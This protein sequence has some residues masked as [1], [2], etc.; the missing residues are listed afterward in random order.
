MGPGLGQASGATR[1]SPRPVILPEHQPGS[2]NC[3][4]SEA[5]VL[6]D[7]PGSSWGV[8][9]HECPWK[10]NSGDFTLIHFASSPHEEVD[11]RGPLG[12]PWAAPQHGKEALLALSHGWTGTPR[13][14]E[15]G[16][17]R[18]GVRL[19][20]KLG[21]A[22]LAAHSQTRASWARPPV[23]ETLA[24]G[25]AEREPLVRPRGHLWA[26]HTAPSLCVR[27]SFASSPSRLTG[28][29]QPAPWTSPEAR[30]GRRA[31]RPPADSCRGLGGPESTRAGA[32]PQPLRLHLGP[33]CT[34]V[35]RGPDSPS[36][37]C[38]PPAGP[39]FTQ[40]LFS[41]GDAGPPA[42]LGL[43]LGRVLPGSRGGMAVEG[44]GGRHWGGGHSSTRAGTAALRN[45]GRGSSTSLVLRGQAVPP[46]ADSL[47]GR[48]VASRRWGISPEAREIDGIPGGPPCAPLG[49]RPGSGGPA[50]EPRGAAGRGEMSQPWPRAAEIRHPH[51]QGHKGCSHGCASC[52]PSP[53]RALYG[54]LSALRPTTAQP[55][56]IFA[57]IKQIRRQGSK[58]R[59]GGQGH[60]GY[61]V[62]VPG[63]HP[64]PPGQKPTPL[65]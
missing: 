52:V 15:E 58:R 17:P 3:G 45:S 10:F 16:L 54:L 49:H 33:L 42:H 47:A 53:Q 60:E 57:S 46:G 41:V 36:T 48:Q 34:P 55:G 12:C 25:P 20:I 61:K 22:G 35:A 31:H 9:K 28:G 8:W 64:G 38:P 13:L 56:G 50:C 2:Q 32:P 21:G 59:G 23:I 51:K 11:T 7:A 19:D 14:R 6:G 63:S 26:P 37:A 5:A 39:P 27:Q 18:A 44:A 30:T 29:L 43:W 65:C 62:A 1:W 40:P 24:S 4:R